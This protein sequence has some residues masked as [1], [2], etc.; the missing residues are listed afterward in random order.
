MNI[1]SLIISASLG[2]NSLCHIPMNPSYLKV[3][4]PSILKQLPDLLK[5][6]SS[7]ILHPVDSEQLETLEKNITRFL[8]K[9]I[10][11]NPKYFEFKELQIQNPDNICNAT[12]KINTPDDFADWP[13]LSQ[14]QYNDRLRLLSDAASLRELYK[15]DPKQGIQVAQNCISQATVLIQQEP[16]KYKTLLKYLELQDIH[17]GIFLFAIAQK[18]T[19]ISDSEGNIILGP[20]SLPDAGNGNGFMQI[21]SYYKSNNRHAYIPYDSFIWFLVK[22]NIIF[23]IK[24]GTTVLTFKLVEITEGHPSEERLLQVSILTLLARYN[25]AEDPYEYARHVIAIYNRILET[26]T[27]PAS[28]KEKYNPIPQI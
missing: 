22:N 14:A 6:S 4:Y 5:R 3:S 13:E 26:P 1:L 10:P 17:P 16:E 11:P 7:F 19:G 18:E 2:L 28:Y 9:N 15:K 12:I 25:A 24:S 21:I 20:G 23:N 27:L 8:I